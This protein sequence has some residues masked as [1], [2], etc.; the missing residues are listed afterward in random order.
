[1]ILTFPA[2]IAMVPHHISAWFC[3]CCCY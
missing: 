1:M 2:T 3:Y